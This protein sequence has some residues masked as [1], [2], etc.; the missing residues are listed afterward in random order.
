MITLCD[1]KIPVE[2]LL[3]VDDLHHTS[4]VVKHLGRYVSKYSDN[5][6]VKSIWR[7]LKRDAFLTHSLELLGT[8]FQNQTDL[9]VHGLNTLPTIF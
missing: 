2:L 4:E 5:L 8:F 6:E 1:F 7:P 3:Q 9:R